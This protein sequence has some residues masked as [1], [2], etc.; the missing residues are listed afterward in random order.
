M[1][2]PEAVGATD[3]TSRPASWAST[4]SAWPGRNSWYLKTWRRTSTGVGT[5]PVWPGR[6]PRSK[7]LYGTGR[8]VL[9]TLAPSRGG[10]IRPDPGAAPGGTSY[11]ERPGALGGP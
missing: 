8:A 1:L 3:S 9:A 10:G 2:L 5:A 4:T 11:A 6:R 7:L